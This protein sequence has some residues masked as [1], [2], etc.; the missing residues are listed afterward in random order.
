MYLRRNITY[1]ER[2]IYW[3]RTT[4][5]SVQYCTNK[6]WKTKEFMVEK[7]NT[8]YQCTDKTKK[9]RKDP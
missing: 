9:L 1:T 2:N 3:Q 7:L 8:V 4:V 6:S 5:L